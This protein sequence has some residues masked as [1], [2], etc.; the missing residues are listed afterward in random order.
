MWGIRGKWGES[1]RIPLRLHRGIM[2]PTH[3]QID[4]KQSL[5]SNEHIKHNR[6]IYTGTALIRSCRRR[7]D[8]WK[9]IVASVLNCHQ[10]SKQSKL[11]APTLPTH[12]AKARCRHAHWNGYHT[13]KMNGSLAE[14]DRAACCFVCVNMF[15]FEQHLFL[16]LM[17]LILQC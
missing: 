13:F 1:S 16:F 6:Y 9:H 2:H 4:L 12:F 8:I 11:S 10:C 7:K 17:L 14:T 3:K 15:M 5:R